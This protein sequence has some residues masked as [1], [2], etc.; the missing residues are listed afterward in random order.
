MEIQKAEIEIRNQIQ[1]PNPKIE[2]LKSKISKIQN[3]K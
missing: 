3:Q 2:N 1:I